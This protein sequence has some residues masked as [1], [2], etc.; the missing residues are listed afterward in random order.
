MLGSGGWALVSVVMGISEPVRKKS[1]A[2][3]I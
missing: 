3:G 2:A 1:Q